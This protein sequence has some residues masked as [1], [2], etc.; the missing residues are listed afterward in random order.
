VKWVV[1]GG[2]SQARPIDFDP[3][4][5]DLL[6]Y[7]KRAQ[8]LASERMNDAVLINMDAEGVYRDGRA[9][10]TLSKSFS[11]NY[12]FRSPSRSKVNPALPDRDQDVPCKLYVIVTAKEIETR[13]AESSDGCKEQALPAPRCSMAQ[14]MERGL[15]NGARSDKVG[16]VTFLTD[17]TWMVDQGDGAGETAYFSCP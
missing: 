13:I 6:G 17:G 3:K 9:D 5:F 11:A 4:H 16:K 15:A 2:D 14:V 8:A 12:G 10:L 1:T 7:A